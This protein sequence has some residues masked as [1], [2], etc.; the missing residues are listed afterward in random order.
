[1]GNCDLEVLAG[2]S[3]FGEISEVG[4][5]HVPNLE[6]IGRANSV[7]SDVANL[8]DTFAIYLTDAV[9]MFPRCEVRDKQKFRTGLGKIEKCI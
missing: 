8:K 9:D 5:V 4:K 6:R 2:R 1:M 7:E 3:D